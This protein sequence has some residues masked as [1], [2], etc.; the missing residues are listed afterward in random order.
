MCPSSSPQSLYTCARPTYNR[1]P[2]RYETTSY[3][4]HLTPFL[5]LTPVDNPQTKL[6]DP[7]TTTVD[8]ST[9]SL[10]LSVFDSLSVSLCT[11]VSLSVYSSVSLF[12]PHLSLSSHSCFLYSKTHFPSPSSF[13]FPGPE[14]RSI[15]RCIFLFVVPGQGRN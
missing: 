7:P 9:P 14:S 15:L 1:R 11:C 8:N 12:Q 3:L 13:P 10:G 2:D 5:P 6:V 4:T